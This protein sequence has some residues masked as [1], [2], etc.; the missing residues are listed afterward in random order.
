MIDGDYRHHPKTRV[1]SFIVRRAFF[2]M[3]WNC[4]VLSNTDIL[5]Q[6]NESNELLYYNIDHENDYDDIICVADKIDYAYRLLT[7]RQCHRIDSSKNILVL[8]LSIVKY[9]SINL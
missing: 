2:I 4:C 3:C 9:E 7:Y 5:V 1:Y 6:K 8:T